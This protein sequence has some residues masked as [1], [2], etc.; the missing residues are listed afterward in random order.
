MAKT[1][2]KPAAK[3]SEYTLRIR[4]WGQNDL[5]EDWH[6]AEFE[7]IAQMIAE[8]YLSGEIVSEDADG[9]WWDLTH[10]ET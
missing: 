3:Q 6:R 5:P 9:G 10:D 8:G 4:Q 1:A 2:N 7:R